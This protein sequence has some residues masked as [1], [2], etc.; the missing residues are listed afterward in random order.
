MLHAMN[1]GCAPFRQSCSS[2]ESSFAKNSLDIGPKNLL[3]SLCLSSWK[4][5]TKNERKLHDPPG[6]GMRQTSRGNAA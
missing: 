1:L 5:Q 6:S 2:F 4:A 3:A